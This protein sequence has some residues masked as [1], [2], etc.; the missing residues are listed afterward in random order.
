[1]GVLDSKIWLVLIRFFSLNLDGNYLC[2]QIAFT[3]FV[4]KAKYFP[5][6]NFLKAAKGSRPFSIW[7]SLLLG[8]EFLTKGIVGMWEMRILLILGLIIGFP[9]FLF[10]NLS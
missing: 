9:L 4:L 3:S 1:M 2:I 5:L 6:T 10:S 7:L 8:R